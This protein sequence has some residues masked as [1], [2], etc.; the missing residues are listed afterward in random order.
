VFKRII[1][2]LIHRLCRAADRSVQGPFPAT[3]SQADLIKRLLAIPHW[4]DKIESYEQY[5]YSEENGCWQKKSAAHPASVNSSHEKILARLEKADD[6]KVHYGCG[7]NIMPDWFNLDLYASDEQDY[8]AINL[9]D[10]HP[11]ANSQVSFAFSEDVLEHLTQADSIF[12]L[13][14]I[15]R[16]LKPGGVLRLSFPGLEGVL[17]QHYSPYS[18]S[19]V[20]QGEFEAYSFWDHVH[21]YSKEELRLVAEHIGFKKIQF[22][23]YGQSAYAELKELDTR[24]HQKALNTFAE[25]IK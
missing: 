16:A 5:A 21:F 22:V 15:Y 7:A 25:L 1:N 10:K 8:F 12:F 6:I 19:R 18:E 2:G 4:Q 13:S 3:I 24:A 23:E 17:T 14:E 9:L 20:R 11:F